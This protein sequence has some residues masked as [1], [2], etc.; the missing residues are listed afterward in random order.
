ME[1]SIASLSTLKLERIKAHQG[2]CTRSNGTFNADDFRICVEV[3]QPCY[4]LDNYAL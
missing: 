2:L 4:Q 3:H 1:V